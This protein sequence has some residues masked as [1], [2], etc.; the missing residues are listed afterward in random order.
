MF[1][2]KENDEEETSSEGEDDK[3]E[4]KE[5]SGLFVKLI[6]LKV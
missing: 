5:L 2:V 4:T 3:E 1:I 6:N